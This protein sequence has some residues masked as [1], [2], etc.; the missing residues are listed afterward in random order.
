MA[1]WEDFD[2]TFAF[3]RDLS[4]DSRLIEQVVSNR[5]ALENVLFVDRL[6]KAI[7]IKAAS[8][9]YPPRSNGTLRQLFQQIVTSSSPNHHKQ[10][11]IYY[12]LRDCRNA[13]DG[14]PSLQF[15]RKYCLPEKYRLFTEGIW[16]L[17]KLE[18]RKALECLTEPSLIP[19][20]P[21]EILYVLST[22]PKPDYSLAT[23]Y[24]L[25][26]S[27]P[28]ASPKTLHAYFDVLCQTR[29][30]ESFY[31]TRKQDDN[32]RH[33]LLERLI[34][35]VHSTKAGELKANRAMDLIN[36]PLSEVE[37]QWFEE[38]L[39]RGKAKHLQGAMDTVMMR[40]IATGRLEN[41]GHDLEA[42]DGRRIDG[43]NWNDLKNN[44]QPG[45]SLIG[46]PDAV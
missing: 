26:V 11:L 1:P 33:E 28:L 12:I 15:A 21:D 22:L 27:P 14:D 23:A 2:A 36:L 25:T 44:L 43:L 37:E 6:L 16:H 3:K 35:F 46:G 20:F 13:G 29:I 18:F 32:L 10:S 17:D 42:L 40:R 30:T 45:A 39:L 38:C 41:L 19:T 7:N 24:Y 4:Y 9:V 5:R 8:K 34:V 31:F